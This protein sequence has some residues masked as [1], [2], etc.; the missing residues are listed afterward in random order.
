[1][2]TH[3]S[4]EEDPAPLD[5]GDGPQTW[6]EA[7]VVDYA[8]RVFQRDGLREPHTH[9][10]MLSGRG[11]VGKYV[12]RLTDDAVRGIFAGKEGYAMS[13]IDGIREL[14]SRFGGAQSLAASI[15]T[16]TPTNSGRAFQNALSGHFLS[17]SGEVKFHEASDERS[18]LKLT[19]NCH[20]ACAWV[21][22][23][24]KE[25]S[26]VI[27]I[28]NVLTGGYLG[29][30]PNGDYTYAKGQHFGAEEWIVSTK[31]GVLG[32]VVL[33]ANYA[34]KYL[35]V[36]NGKLTGVSSQCPECVWNIV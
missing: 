25:G 13:L 20:D 22:E 16:V 10:Q 36:V 26:Q 32:A 6:T 17:E 14:T 3:A 33:F 30:D 24:Q 35:A 4:R 27:L 12:I 28:K 31:S 18:T 29:Y 34:Q 2:S 21:E 7:D 23:G 11:I 1:M 8:K 19:I 9:A 15:A 5:V